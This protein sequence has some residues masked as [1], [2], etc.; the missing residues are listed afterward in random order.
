MLSLHLAA[1]VH[2]EES[3]TVFFCPILPVNIQTEQD[4]NIISY[5]Y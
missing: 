2:G 3:L 1:D 5:N 4:H